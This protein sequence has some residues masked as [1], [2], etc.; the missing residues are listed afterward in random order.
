[1][2]GSANLYR[3][4]KFGNDRRSVELQQATLTVAKGLKVTAGGQ[5]VT[6]G[7]LKVVAGDIYGGSKIYVGGTTTDAPCLSAGTV[8][9]TLFYGLGSIYVDTVTA[10]LYVQTATETWKQF[11][12]PF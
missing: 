10:K 3:F 4:F 9:P 7:D 11:A 2:G 8:E 5:T 6:A 1:M 12:T